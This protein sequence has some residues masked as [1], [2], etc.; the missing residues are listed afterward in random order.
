MA[1]PFEKAVTILEYDKILSLLAGQCAVEA[2]KE[3]IL[4]L[5][6]EGDFSRVVRL[7]IRFG[8]RWNSYDAARMQ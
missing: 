2:G 6:P 8:E 7:Q 4:T 3:K 5:R 1:K